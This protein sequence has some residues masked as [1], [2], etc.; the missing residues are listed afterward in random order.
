[1][2][3]SDLKRVTE[4]KNERH[5]LHNIIAAI[6]GVSVDYFE[7]NTALDCIRLHRGAGDEAARKTFELV[8]CALFD[9][10][11]GRLIENTAALRDLGVDI[12]H[13]D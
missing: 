12:S 6:T 2:K 11:N 1:M 8:R 13:D 4:L 5:N 9:L 10:L 3:L 7:I